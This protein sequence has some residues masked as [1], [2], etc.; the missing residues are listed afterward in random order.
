MSTPILAIG[1]DVA[2][3][4]LIEQW[5][6]DGYLPTIASII[7]AGSWKKILSTSDLS[8]GSIWPSFSTG[9]SPA[10]HGQ[11]FTHM[12]FSNGTYQIDKKYA[13]QVKRPPFWMS[14]HQAGK[15]VGV[16]DIPQTV[17]M[18]GFNGVQVVGWG[19][20]YPAWEKSS[21]PPS[22]IKEILSRFGRHP[23]AD[24]YR[25]SIKPSS[26]R[27]YK[28]ISKK[29]LAGAEKKAQITKYLLEQGPWDLFLTVFP[30]THWANHLLWHSLDNTHPDYDP[31][32]MNE[33]EDIFLRL[34]TLID[35]WLS[36]FIEVMP[37]STVMVFSLSGM[38]PNYSG[39]H[40]LQD[41]LEKFGMTQPARISPSN[42]RDSKGVSNLAKGWNWALPMK[43]WGS[44]KIRK[45]ED[46]VSLSAIQVGKRVVPARIWDKW[47]RRLLFTGNN[48][49]ESRA[50][51]IPNDYSGAIRINLKG[52]EP[53]GL[54]EPGKE[55][56]D[57]CE[58][59]IQKLGPLV[60]PDTG[61]A[62]VSCVVRVDKLYKG[63]NLFDL[64]DLIVCWASD[65]PIRALY[66]PDIG[67]VCGNNPERRTGAH[68]PHGFFLASGQ[69]IQTG[70]RFSEGSIMDIA[71]TILYLL[72]EPIPTD[73]DGK[74]LL[75]IIEDEF[76]AQNPPQYD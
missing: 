70:K 72:G 26:S 62:A 69:N 9:T 39:W 2:S 16:M 1:I 28:E 3:P 47:T 65:A 34:F 24:E 55:Y 5:V 33:F 42:Y 40:L 19:A 71:P 75:E 22:L 37:E 4:E 64:P 67:T 17:P 23:L 48:W 60:N 51:C 56:D 45:V 30:E 31:S 29:L 49:N 11:Y 52:R 74:V 36:K 66:S 43:K 18:K 76:K 6:K 7:N 54:V 73:M 61:R 50:F 12:Q 13:D 32:M 27:E 63:E 10:K 20:E 58:E 46:I 8:S 68:R 59:L 14:L 38:G 35:A 41:V 25:L 44:Y 53:N 21:W 15:R 57:L